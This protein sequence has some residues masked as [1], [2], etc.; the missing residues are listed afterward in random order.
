M[1]ALLSWRTMVLYSV[2]NAGSSMV[3]AFTNAALPLYLL[4]YGLP[5]WLV[6]L[7]A[8]ERSGIGGIVQ[9][10]IGALSDRTRTRL[11]KRRPYFLVGV[12]LTAVALIALG[13]HP[14]LPVTVALISILALLLAVANDPYV[15]LMADIAPPEQRGRIGSLM[16]IFGMGAQVVVLLA[17]VYLWES[18]ELWVII[19]IAVGLVLSFGITFFGVREPAS[20]ELAGRVARPKLGLVPYLRDVLGHREVAKYSLA[21][22]FFWLG[23]GAAAPFITRFAVVDL[24][25]SESM[26][27]VLMLLLVLAAGICAYP[28]GLLGDRFGKKRVMS[29]ALGFFA[30]AILV[31]SQARTMEQLV[32]AIIL[33]GVGSTIPFVLNLP[34][35]V[36]LIPHERAGE[37]VGLGSMLWSIGQPLGALV[38]GSLA[39]VSGGYRLTFVFAGVMML[40]S[41]LVLQTVR[42]PRLH[43]REGTVPG[44]E[45]SVGVAPAPEASI[46]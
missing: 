36:D 24:S 23:Q 14:P 26:G 43:I 20:T 9:P 44:P 3:A 22:A 16:A 8:Q 41:L 4:P 19:G 32:P 42:P 18:H 40:A 30:G 34:M 28:A 33:V 35:L 17:A 6:G 2:G 39:D 7:L 21:M 29:V 11:G 31:G 38:G 1:S 10:M 25:L 45:L 46:G 13:L 5:G 27:F 37:F 12:P 15:A